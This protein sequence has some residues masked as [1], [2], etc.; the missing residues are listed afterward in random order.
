MSVVLTIKGNNIEVQKP[1]KDPKTVY[2]PASVRAEV[3]NRIATKCM[4]K[5]IKMEIREE[6][7]KQAP[8]NATPKIYTHV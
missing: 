1:G 7:Q 2:V 5:G 6:P 4:A 8:F 3:I